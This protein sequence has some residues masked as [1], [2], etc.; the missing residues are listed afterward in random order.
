MAA[1]GPVSVWFRCAT[2]PQNHQ[3][4]TLSIL[5]FL[6]PTVFSLSLPAA[7]RAV[8]LRPCPAWRG[9][10]PAAVS[11]LKKFV[12][13]IRRCLMG[14]IFLDPTDKVDYGEKTFAP[15]LDTL[16][17]KTIGL[18]DINKAKGS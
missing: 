10:T 9:A 1:R 3:L 5:S 11:L 17:G 2:N 15:G 7:R 18:L 13:R 4:M 6:R 8:S 14:E 12:A 16:A